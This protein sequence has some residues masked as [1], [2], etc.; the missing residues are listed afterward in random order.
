MTYKDN[1]PEISIIVPLYNEVENVPILHQKISGTM[2][3][4]NRTYEVVYINDGSSDGTLDALMSLPN[5][6]KN[7]LILNLKGNNGQTAALAA[8]FDYA[9]GNI[10]VSLDG[11]LQ[12]D[13]SEI[14]NFIKEIDAGYDIVSGWR[15]HRVD[16]YFSRKLPSR[17]A[18]WIM[19]KWSGVPLHD[20]GTT[21]KAYRSEVIK[22]VSLYGEF[23]RFIPVLVEGMKINI[24]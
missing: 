3:I 22:S 20:F 17:V 19:A 1:L 15:E 5:E 14:P 12:H 16:P 23:H 18:N 21:F 9:R 11:D 8:G 2:K 6:E 10:I 7:I 24:K 4:L 13:P